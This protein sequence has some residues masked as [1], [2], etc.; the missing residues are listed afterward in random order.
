MALSL[1]IIILLY[2]GNSCF[3]V[4]DVL[5]IFQDGGRDVGNLHG[6][7]RHSFEREKLC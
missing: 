6:L 3:F 5:S 4:V 2:F 1:I 7:C